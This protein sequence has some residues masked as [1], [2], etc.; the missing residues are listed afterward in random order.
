MIYYHNNN[1]IKIESNDEL[2]EINFR[3]Y[4]DDIIDLI[5]KVLPTTFLLVCF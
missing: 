2:K 5:L 1:I 3:N 4:N